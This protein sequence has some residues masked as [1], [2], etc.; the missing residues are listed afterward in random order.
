MKKNQPSKDILTKA[1]SVFI[2]FLQENE[3][4]D[5]N[6][7][8]SS[9]PGIRQI[10]HE[11]GTNGLRFYLLEARR[12]DYTL[13]P[14]I[15]ERAGRLL[16]SKKILCIYKICLINAVIFLVKGNLRI[17]YLVSERK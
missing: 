9:D 13:D 5:P 7:L 16:V 17:N 10:K 8:Q 2:D 14:D 15:E 3:R 4:R 12:L 11:I 1:I 6:D